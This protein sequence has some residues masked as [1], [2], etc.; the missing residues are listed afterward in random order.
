M[1]IFCSYGLLF[2]CNLRYNKKHQLGCIP[3]PRIQSYFTVANDEI[4]GS[5]LIILYSQLLQR[6]NNLKILT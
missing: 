3:Q 1:R 2:T 4:E 5:L 6:T